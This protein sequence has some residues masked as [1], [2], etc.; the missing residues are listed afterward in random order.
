MQTAK[1]RLASLDAF[2]GFV[3]LAM[4]WVNYIAG[5]PGIPHWL[6]HAGPKTD[7]VT[8][9]DLV[10]PAFLLIVGMAIPLALH[11]E[12]GR[13]GAALLGRLLWRAGS[14]MVAGVVLANA[15]RY[16]AATA[17]LPRAV[18]FLLFYVA[19]ILLWRQGGSRRSPAFWLGAA[20]MV[21]LLAAFRGEI[22]AEFSAV[23]LQH[24]WWGILGMIGWAYL[25]CS[26]L[27][28]ATRGDGAA[29]TGCLALLVALYMG[30]TAGALPL[31][32]ALMAFVNV[33]QV[34]GSTA[35]NVMAGA[36]V[37][38]LFLRDGDGQPVAHGRRIRFMA[39]FALALFAAGLLLRPY[40]GINKI[41]ATAAYTLVCAGLV[42][43][44]F[45]LFYVLIDVL[46]W[47]A[48]SAMLMPA[49]ANALFAYIAP[50]LWEQLAA[51]LRLPRFW[52]PY[53]A[54]G[55][56]PGLLN[57]A[58]MTLAMMGLTA[59]ANRAGLKLKF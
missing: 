38:R 32:G 50:D 36:V 3:I 37:G 35:A 33:P 18:Y 24:T 44:L 31:P 27:Y 28:L 40:H 21:F 54:S 39:W 7:G 6:E 59:L 11:K 41:H 10:F 15:Y 8:L 1:P 17:L 20:L 16:D 58:A 48:W 53:L 5:M 23:H 46:G 29:L 47:G 45:L 19:M 9:P 22:N 25:L 14:L 4:I 30:G 13:F 56:V 12:C 51:A 34:L 43:A 49:G 55:G 57:A 2:R 52:W 42:L 26:L